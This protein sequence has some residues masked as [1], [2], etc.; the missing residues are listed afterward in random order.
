MHNTCQHNEHYITLMIYITTLIGLI[1]RIIPCRLSKI[2][3]PS[4]DLSIRGGAGTFTHL[5]W[6]LVPPD[7]KEYCI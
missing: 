3:I 5:K 4:T 7:F 2:N 1:F 6:S